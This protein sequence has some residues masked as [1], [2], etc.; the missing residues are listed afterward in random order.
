[1]ETRFED[2]CEETHLDVLRDFVARHHLGV[3]DKSR[4]GLL[5]KIRA[6]F[7]AE[8]VTKRIGIASKNVVVTSGEHPRKVDAEKVA[9]APSNKPTNRDNTVDKG[10]NNLCN[11]VNLALCCC[12]KEATAAESTTSTDKYHV[13]QKVTER[14]SDEDREIAPKIPKKQAPGANKSSSEGIGRAIKEQEQDA[15]GGAVEKLVDGCIT[16]TEQHIKANKAIAK[17]PAPKPVEDSNVLVH[18]VEGTPA[19]VGQSSSHSVVTGGKGKQK[20]LV[21]IEGAADMDCNAMMSTLSHLIRD[22]GISRYHIVPSPTAAIMSRSLAE[23]FN[24]LRRRD[25][26]LRQHGP[27]HSYYLR[28]RRP[29]LTSELSPVDQVDHIFECQMLAHSIFQTKGYHKVLSQI[30]TSGSDKSLNIG[31]NSI[32]PEVV[33][34]A[35]KQLKDL[36]NCANDETLFN[37]KM[38]A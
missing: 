26:V 8:E 32:Q 21:R 14:K 20:V 37:L 5:V 36:H 1:M 12:K 27:V 16:S 38:Y 2:L 31:R 11:L 4:A 34:N 7:T 33:K 9:E 10:P 6:V 15:S 35:M 23:Y 3:K 22:D 19:V 13:V 25:D 18:N 30:E 28:P 29:P 17:V 24:L